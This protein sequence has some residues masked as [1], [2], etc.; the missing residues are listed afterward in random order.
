MSE[1][2]QWEALNELTAIQDYIFS[3]IDPFSKTHPEL[4]Q[5]VRQRALE[6]GDIFNAYDEKWKTHGFGLRGTKER[7]G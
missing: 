3:R 7:E 6:I 1:Y 2:T 5:E 4:Y